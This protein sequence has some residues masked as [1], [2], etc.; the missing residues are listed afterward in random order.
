MNHVK[1]YLLG[2]WQF[3]TNWTTH[4]AYEYARSY[5]AGR[6]IAHWLTFR[7]YEQ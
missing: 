4:V 7:K 1:A 3:R 2:V 6:D 5:D